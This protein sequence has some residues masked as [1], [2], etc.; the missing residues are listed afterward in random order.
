MAT[1]TGGGGWFGVGCWG[2]FGICRSRFR[3]TS[4]HVDHRATSNF[5]QLCHKHLKK[6]ISVIW[7]MGDWGFGRVNFFVKFL[8]NNLNICFWILNHQSYFPWGIF[9]FSLKMI[10]NRKKSRRRKKEDETTKISWNEVISCSSSESYSDMAFFSVF[11]KEK[12][13]NRKTKTAKSIKFSSYLSDFVFGPW[14]KP[15]IKILLLN[16]YMKQI[17]KK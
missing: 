1:L 2:F 15:L 6:L 5:A 12:K 8:A 17:D 13:M 4:G 11:V 10:S 7:E 9:L 14:Y 3:S 16:S